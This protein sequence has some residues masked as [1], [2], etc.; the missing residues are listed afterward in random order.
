MW[1][2]S[3]DFASKRKQ[4]RLVSWVEKASLERIRRL[5]EI[6]KAEHNQNHLLSMKN[7][8]KLGA[9]PFRYIVPIIPRPLPAEL[10]EGEHF[11]L[12]NIFKSIPGSSSQ[13][14]SNQ[15]GVFEG[16]SVKFFLPYQLSLPEQDPQPAPQAVK[17]KKKAKKGG[18][19]KSVDARLKGFVG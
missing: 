7:L 2:F 8:R 15:A 4:G 14:G 6:T 12:A 13:V 16:A 17:K 11:V 10:V 18:Q 5:L 3:S 1:L 19:T 9:S